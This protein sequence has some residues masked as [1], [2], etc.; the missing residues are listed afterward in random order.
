MMMM[1]I[2]NFK[3][4][5]QKIN[6]LMLC[7]IA[8]NTISYHQTFVIYAIVLISLIKKKIVMSKR[9]MEAQRQHQIGVEYCNN[10]QTHWMSPTLIQ[11]AMHFGGATNDSSCCH[12]LGWHLHHHHLVSVVK[13]GTVAQ[14]W[15]YGG[16]KNHPWDYREMNEVK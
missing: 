9:V 16:V 8:G 11:L 7:D 12:P 15:V 10:D 4:C 1:I 5:I 14:Y 2:L 3:N 13:F 6:P